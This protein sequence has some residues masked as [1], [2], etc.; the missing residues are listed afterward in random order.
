MFS[1]S[2]GQPQDFQPQHSQPQNAMNDTHPNP[3]SASASAQPNAA[4]RS[5]RPRNLA[6]LSLAVAV[7]APVAMSAWSRLHIGEPVLA[8]QQPALAPADALRQGITQYRNGQYE[9]AVATF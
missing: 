9:E 4:R 6:A 1:S 2:K 5:Q 8:V 7:A 3:P